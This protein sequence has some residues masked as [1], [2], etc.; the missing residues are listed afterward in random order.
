MALENFHLINGS[1]SEIV[2]MKANDF[3]TNIDKMHN[4][5]V[6]LIILVNKSLVYS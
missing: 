2:D 5:L 1:T 3:L 4:L 6:H